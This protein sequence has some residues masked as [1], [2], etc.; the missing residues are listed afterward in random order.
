MIARFMTNVFYFLCWCAFSFFL[1]SAAMM[2]D[3]AHRDSSKIEQAINCV[4]KENQE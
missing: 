2:F 1:L 3:S 4:E